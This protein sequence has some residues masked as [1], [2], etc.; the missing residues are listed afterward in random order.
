MFN[1]ILNE[2]IPS[3]KS[4]MSEEISHSALKTYQGGDENVFEHLFLM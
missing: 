2:V 1:D 3:F 4:F